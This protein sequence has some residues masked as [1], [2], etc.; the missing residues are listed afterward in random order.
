MS[1]FSTLHQSQM[2]KREKMLKTIN[3]FL[4]L[5]MIFLMLS[6]STFCYEPNP[7]KPLAGKFAEKEGHYELLVRNIN[8][9]IDPGEWLEIEGYITGYGIIQNSKL[10]IFVSS[11]IFEKESSIIHVDLTKK[12]NG[13]I[14]GGNPMPFEFGKVIDYSGGLKLKNWAQRTMFFDLS[15]KGET[16]IISTE[17]KQG[18]APIFLRLKTKGKSKSGMYTMHFAFTYFNGIGWK[19]SRQDIKFTV[20]NVLQRNE[21]FAWWIA[22]IATLIAITRGITAILKFFYKKGTKKDNL[23]NQSTQPDSASNGAPSGR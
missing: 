4:I 20:R 19:G 8:P 14:F 16:P 2:A 21:N 23:T 10:A 9:V 1:P 3:T 6:P 5:V 13:I 18:Q 15:K 17:T 12:E 11:E 22:I 7:E